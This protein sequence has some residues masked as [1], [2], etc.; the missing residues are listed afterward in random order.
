MIMLRRSLAALLSL[1]LLVGSAPRMGG[2]SARGAPA[3]ARGRAARAAG[4]GPAG[5][6]AHRF[7]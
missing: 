4:R 5:R 2:G 3:P 1:T 6:F 7:R